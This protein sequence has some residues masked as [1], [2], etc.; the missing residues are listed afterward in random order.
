V[1]SQA[2]SPSA[3]SALT[4][5]RFR[6][7]LLSELGKEGV[8]F[9]QASR[10]AFRTPRDFHAPPTTAIG[11]ELLGD[12]RE[13]YSRQLPVSWYYEGLHDADGF[14]A[15]EGVDAPTFV[16]I[17]GIFGEFI[18]Q[19]PFQEALGPA[20]SSFARRWSSTLESIP[21]QRFRLQD[22]DRV[23]ISLS[24]SVRLGGI[25]R[26]GKSIANLVV[27]AP[28][29]G[30]LETLGTLES[31]AAVHLRRLTRL[32][33]SIQD[34]S[35][36]YLI[37][38]SRGLA[39]ALEMVS[40]LYESSRA[41][42]LDAPTDAWFG[43]LRGVIGL[44]GGFYGAS[45]AA[46]VL[47]GRAG[48]TSDLV[49][50]LRSTAGELVTIPDSASL[51]DK[52]AGVALNAKTWSGF[53]RALTTADTPKPGRGHSFLGARVDEAIA[54]EAKV[55]L[56]GRDLPAPSPWGIWSVVNRFFLQTFELRQF[57]GRY[58]E[59]VTGLKTLVEA[60]LT[61]VETLTPRA[62]D[63]WWRSHQLPSELKIFSITGTMPDAHLDGLRSPLW[64]F[65]GYGTRTSDYNVS[66]RSAFYDTMVAEGTMINDS[67]VSHA[68]SRYWEQMYPEH[69]YEHH[70]LGALGTHHWGMAFPFTI[71]DDEKV[72]A[73]PFPR[74][75][76]L[77]ALATYVS[78][79]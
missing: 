60:V 15:I 28:T 19:L 78:A 27:F 21:D 47:G 43:R 14:T 54:A 42:S 36:L 53:V 11:L 4:E 10:L 66:L 57:V 51:K 73:N 63:E 33:E 46:E 37:G 12:F 41:G 20:G 31:N 48:A 16:V 65:D 58:N 50:L 35:D 49:K 79:P 55:R 70:Y 68:C 52:A 71:E 13:H 61:G 44:G 34:H 39:V 25:D 72:G 22:L 77:R 17:P 75:T 45:F 26:D 59:N 67:Q 69:R 2:E 7:I 8:A 30:S 23:D 1:A 40:S 38:Y 64:E 56:L 6:S 9:E 18:D 29:A 76:L 62:R 3:R 24:E 32:F 74:S 5:E